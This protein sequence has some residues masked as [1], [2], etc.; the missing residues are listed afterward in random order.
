MWMLFCTL[1]LK[2]LRLL[3]CFSK[4]N[5]WIDGS[6]CLYLL[7]NS[8]KDC[9][10]DFST[11]RSLQETGM[12]ANET[13]INSMVLAATVVTTEGIA[14]S[15]VA[16]PIVLVFKHLVS[17]LVCSDCYESIFIILCYFYVISINTY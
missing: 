2:I 11:C 3:E 9:S 8:I 10:L 15:S 6:R 14:I 16:E 1:Q 5:L 13:Q 12:A 4:K 17:P 7:K